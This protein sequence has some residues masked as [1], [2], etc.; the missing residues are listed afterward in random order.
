MAINAEGLVG[1]LRFYPSGS[2]KADYIN[3]PATSNRV[4]TTY[5]QWQLFVF[6]I[7]NIDI[8]GASPKFGKITKM[9]FITTSQF[10]V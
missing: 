3:N 9:G 7:D 5:V 8:S 10:T 4:N 1:L 6:K 2:I